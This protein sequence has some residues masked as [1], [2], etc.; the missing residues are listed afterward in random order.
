VPSIIIENIKKH[1]VQLSR[2]GL[3]SPVQNFEVTYTV[4]NTLAYLPRVL[5]TIK[6]FKTLVPGVCII[7]LV[8]TVINDLL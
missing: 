1:D 4:A 6:K 7:K 5:V 3:F 8:T 2:T